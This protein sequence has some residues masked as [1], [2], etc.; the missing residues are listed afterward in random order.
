MFLNALISVDKVLEITEITE[1]TEGFSYPFTMSPPAVSLY[2]L[3]TERG[4]DVRNAQGTLIG[5]TT[6]YRA[7]A[8][9][10]T[11]IGSIEIDTGNDETV[12]ISGYGTKTRQGIWWSR[13]GA[14]LGG[15]GR[16]YFLVKPND[17]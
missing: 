14:E 11:S 8:H 16:R 5:T 4:V 7:I 10:G 13:P 3:S 2:Y 12:W 15:E 17:W 9:N 6:D 1:T